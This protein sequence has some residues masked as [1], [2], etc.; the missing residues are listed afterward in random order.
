MTEREARLKAARDQ[1]AAELRDAAVAGGASYDE[2]QRG[3]EKTADQAAE[4]AE[5]RH[6]E[7]R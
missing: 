6:R 7:R 2:A 3:A 4:I 5:R 1:R